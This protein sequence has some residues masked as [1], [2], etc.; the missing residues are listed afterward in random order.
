MYEQVELW[1]PAGEAAYLCKK[2]EIAADYF[3]RS[4]DY[5]RAIDSYE[6]VRNWDKILNT[7][8]KYK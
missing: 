5:I 3:D 6:R 8:K 1:K 2:Y 4:G 7:I